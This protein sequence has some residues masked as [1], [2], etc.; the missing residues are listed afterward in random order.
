MVLFDDIEEFEDIEN[1]I[2][3]TLSLD[4]NELRHYFF[5]QKIDLT[6]SEECV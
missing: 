2:S 1:E 5:S 6:I 3:L 4:L